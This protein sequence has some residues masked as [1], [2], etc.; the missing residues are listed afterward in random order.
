MQPQHPS[1]VSAPATCRSQCAGARG[2]AGTAGVSERRLDPTCSFLLLLAALLRITELL[3]L[4]DLSTCGPETGASQS[5]AASD[6]V[7]CMS[8]CGLIGLN[9]LNKAAQYTHAGGTVVA[10]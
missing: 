5:L 4:P 1:L 6:A 7:G 2:R 3:S 8:I 9:W 10:P